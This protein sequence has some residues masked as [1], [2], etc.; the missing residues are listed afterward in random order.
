MVLIVKNCISG[1]ACSSH[2]MMKNASKTDIDNING[3]TGGASVPLTLNGTR[4]PKYNLMHI[5]N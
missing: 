5:L 2:T 3:G 4:E 1:Q